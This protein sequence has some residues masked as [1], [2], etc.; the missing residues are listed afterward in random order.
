MATVTISRNLVVDGT[1][2]GR[3][4]AADQITAGHIGTNEIIA[5]SA[6]I[7]GRYYLCEHCEATII[8]AN[9]AGLRLPMLIQDLSVEKLTAGNIGA[10][11][12]TLGGSGTSRVELNAENQSIRVYHD[13]VL[14]VELGRL[15]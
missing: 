11:V 15:S 7:A 1:I 14:R 13:G 5:H 3:S 2:L 10:E 9:M 12:I 4:I 8:G 6:N